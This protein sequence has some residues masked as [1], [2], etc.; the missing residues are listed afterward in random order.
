MKEAISVITELCDRSLLLLPSPLLPQ[1]WGGG[2]DAVPT[3]TIM[4][5]GDTCTRG[6]NFCAVA[7]ARNPAPLDPDEPRHVAEAVK[8][9]GLSYV[10]LTSVD[11]DD[12]VRVP[13]ASICSIAL[14]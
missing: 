1:C 14:Q 6:C 11:R 4:I 10:V 2:P 7:T 8:S 13:C 5:M 9:W 3:G 12:L